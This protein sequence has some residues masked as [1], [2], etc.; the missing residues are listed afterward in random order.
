MAG[1]RGGGAAA[2]GRS[3]AN[4]GTALTNANAPAINIRFIRV[5]CSVTRNSGAA[6]MRLAFNDLRPQTNNYRI[7]PLKGVAKK[8]QRATL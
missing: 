7:F 6:S 5:S 1:A 8:Q 3:A 4:A 2:G